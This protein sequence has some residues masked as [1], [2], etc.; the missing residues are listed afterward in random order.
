[1]RRRKSCVAM[2]VLA[3]V[4]GPTRPASAY[5]KFGTTV[6]GETVTVR[7]A[8]TPI[9]YFVSS[10]NT[11]PGIGVNDLM[12]AVAR[13]FGR[14]QA[15][16]TANVSYQFAGLTDA[17]PGADDGMSVLGFENHPEL[18]RVLAATSFLVDRATGELLEADIFFNS[19]F[20][21][22]VAAAGET[23]K[24]DFESIALHEIGHFS[25]LS[26]SMLG[27]TELTA[28]GG[29]RVVSAEAVM[30]P[31]AFT[32]GSIAARTP[33]ADDI[34]GI[35]DLYPASGFS[36]LGSLS[37]RVLKNGQPVFGAHVVAFDL[38]RGDLVASFTLSTQGTFS[39]GGLSPG[40]H[41]VRV[42]PLD[43]A[44]ITSFFDASAPVDMNFLV[45]LSNQL[46]VVPRGGDSGSVDFNVTS[47]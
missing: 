14:W 24:Y 46:V 1:M 5:L 41:I 21:W 8:R 29:R 39:I 45:L 30:F 6:N 32:A 23:N 13:A 12:A 26:H 10:H 47:K 3:L 17:Q 38:A 7:W 36:A 9:Q 31:I 42:E 4:A 33:K 40:P 37:G 2:L 22:S 44:D 43:D 34:A 27:Q 35:S 19:S 16:P 11:V 20:Q 25:G 28:G 18:A 15:V